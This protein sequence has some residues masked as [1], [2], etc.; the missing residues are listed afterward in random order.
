MFQA[1]NDDPQPRGLGVRVLDDNTRLRGLPGN[2]SADQILIAHRIDEQRD[3]VLHH[4]R[5]V[6]A[7]GFV[8]RE[9]VLEAG[10]SA[11]VT[12]TPA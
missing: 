9:A 4:G 6:F 8:E 3:A 12:N 1:E 5:I 11:A 7:D 10:A 2:R